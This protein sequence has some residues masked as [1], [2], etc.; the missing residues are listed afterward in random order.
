MFSESF[1]RAITTKHIPR[2]KFSVR[3]ISW[4]K[5]IFSISSRH[6]SIRFVTNFVDFALLCMIRGKSI[7]IQLHF[8][9]LFRVQR[10]EGSHR[11]AGE[12][13]GKARKERLKR[14]DLKSLAR[15]CARV[16]DAAPRI[17]WNSH[18]VAK[19]ALYIGES[20]R[21]THR[22]GRRE[23]DF[24]SCD[25]NGKTSWESAT[26]REELST[27]ARFHGDNRSGLALGKTE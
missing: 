16:R 15:I 7:Y 8:S 11:F 21:I 1:L 13:R 6:I 25:T 10:G 12:R 2:R 14:G 4:L 22:T 3:K 5:I 9:A 18:R 24:Y 19:K 17:A 26:S 27:L 20:A 23:S